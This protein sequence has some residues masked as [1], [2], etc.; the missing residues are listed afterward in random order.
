VGEGTAV[1]VGAEVGV[2]VA[3][4]SVG[5]GV[6]SRGGEVGAE[7]GGALLQAS[8][9]DPDIRTINTRNCLIPNDMVRVRSDN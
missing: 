8:A 4:S 6:A 7:A 9:I 3:G 2:T 5:D 1:S